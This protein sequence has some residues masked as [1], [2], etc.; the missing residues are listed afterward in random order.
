MNT[1]SHGTFLRSK[2]TLTVTIDFLNWLKNISL[3]TVDQQHL[4]AWQAEG[5]TTRE[6]ASRFLRWAMGARLV[7]RTLTMTPHRR[8]TSTTLP[9]ADQQAAID[10][11]VNTDELT[12]RDRLA[13]ILILVF[14]QQAADI[15]QLTWDDVTVTDELVTISIGESPIALSPPLDEPARQLVAAPGHAQTAAHPDSR[16]VFRGHAPGGHITA[17][18]LR[19]RLKA[20]FS[21]RAARLGTLHELTKLAPVAI[22]ADT[23]GYA[24]ATIERHATAAAS[25]YAQYIPAIRGRL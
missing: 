1:V 25:T 6:I 4:D 15:V 3:A 5:P 24:P 23:L 10:R 14:G 11:V 8:G 17:A 16:W 12:A 20:L 13:A 21:T 2:Q 7:D 9:A 18:A 19:E 22:I